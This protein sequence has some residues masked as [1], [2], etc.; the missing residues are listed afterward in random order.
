VVAMGRVLWDPSTSNLPG[1]YCQDDKK[2][3]NILAMRCFLVGTAPRYVFSYAKFRQRL[4]DIANHAHC[5]TEQMFPYHHSKI[6]MGTQIMYGND[7]VFR[8]ISTI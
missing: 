1:T 3:E 7:R 2:M 5:T 4:I 8:A 6:M